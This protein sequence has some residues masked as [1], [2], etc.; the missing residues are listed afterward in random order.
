M[1]S[2]RGDGGPLVVVGQIESLSSNTLK[3]II[4]QGV[5]HTHGLG[6]GSGISLGT[7]RDGILGQFTR[8]EEP[9][10]GLNFTRGMMVDLLL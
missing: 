7:F 10:G 2:P 1:N 6:E 9:D 5:H 4:D 8:A 3:E